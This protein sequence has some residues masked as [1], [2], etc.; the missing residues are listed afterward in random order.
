VRVIRDQAAK[1]TWLVYNT[2]IKKIL[3]KFVLDSWKCLST[4]LP[5]TKLVK[6]TENQAILAKIK[7]YQKK[8]GSLLYTAIMI[9]PDVAFA[10][11]QLLQFLTNL[12]KKHIKAVNWAIMYLWGTRFLV[13]QYKKEHSKI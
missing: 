4:P 13:I 12:S 9:R 7:E 3:K 2:Y 5:R 11:A 8:V 10:A 1:K 6:N